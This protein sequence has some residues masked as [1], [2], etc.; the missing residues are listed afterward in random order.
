MKSESAFV[1]AAD[2]NYDSLIPAEYKLAGRQAEKFYPFSVP[3]SNRKNL[4][5]LPGTIIADSYGAYKNIQIKSF[6]L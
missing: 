4:Q 5:S 1:S 2:R 6:T 3:P